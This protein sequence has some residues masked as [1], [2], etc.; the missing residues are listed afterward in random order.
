MKKHK[1]TP[2]PKVIYSKEKR[3]PTPSPKSWMLMVTVL[4]ALAAI[5]AVWKFRE[6]GRFVTEFVKVQK[7]Y[8]V[9]RT[10]VAS[11]DETQVIETLKQVGE[12]AKAMPWFNQAHEHVLVT[13]IDLNNLPLTISV[14]KGQYSIRVGWFEPEKKTLQ[15]AVRRMHINRLSQII[16]DSQFT[17]SEL[18]EVASV[19]LVPALESL[20][21]ADVLYFPGDKRFLELDNMMHVEVMN[22]FNLKDEYGNMLTAQATVTNVDG[23]WLV[24]PGLKGNPDVKYV[25]TV[26]QMLHYY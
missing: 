6:P 13:V 11:S 21:S 5:V 12:K 1:A 22:D 17:Q 15:V 23:Q 18:Y 10:E 14:D 25:V 19:A 3:E 8:A 24:F 16:A 9:G 20:Y 2:E 4:I 7:D 26:D